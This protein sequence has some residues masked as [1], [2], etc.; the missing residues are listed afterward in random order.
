MKLGRWHGR[1]DAAISKNRIGFTLIELLVVISIMGILAALLLPVLSKS[2]NHA[3]RTTCQNNVR[4]LQLG[5]ILYAHDFDDH[6]PRN[7]V[8]RADGQFPQYP[9]WV[10]GNM[11]MNCDVG[12]DLTQST[13]TVFLVGSQYA[14]CGSIGVYVKNPA[15]YRCPVDPST[16]T[17]NG[18]I[19]PRVRSMSMNA[20]MGGP[21]QMK[22][23]REF[24]NM[25]DIIAP[26]PS[27]A[28]V[29]MD[30]RCDSINDGLFAIDA[31]AQYAI[32]D[33]PANY[34]NG[35]SCLSF[36]DGHMEYHKWVEATTEPPMNPNQRLPSGPKPTSTN[37]RDMQWLVSHTTSKN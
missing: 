31:A 37:D 24:L 10:A 32:V 22:A 11:W 18:A 20:Y 30:E 36:A 15:V 25:R 13:N 8:G 1:P 16:I 5:W 23:Y 26:G 35:G 29:L 27:D 33:Y 6:L 34:H 17:I 2:K 3:E 7:S 12:Q 28:W 19:M 4:Q 9:G 21:V 14:V